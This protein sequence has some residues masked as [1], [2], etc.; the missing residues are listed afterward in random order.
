MQPIEYNL[1][2]VSA[3][4]FSLTDTNPSTHVLPMLKQL[5]PILLTEDPLQNLL[6]FSDA[7]RYPLIIEC[8]KGVQVSG[9]TAIT[10]V[11][12]TTCLIKLAMELTRAPPP[13]GTTI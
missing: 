13:E 1:I 12:G 9:S 5:S 7:T 11:F 3:N 8:E 2:M 10:F 6:T 4:L